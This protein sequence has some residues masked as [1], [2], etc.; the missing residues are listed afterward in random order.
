MNEDAELFQMSKDIVCFYGQNEKGE[1]M[2]FRAVYTDNSHFTKDTNPK[3][4]RAN[5]EL[6]G[7]EFADSL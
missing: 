3:M 4:Y 5:V 2:Y 1:T 7:Q 6:F